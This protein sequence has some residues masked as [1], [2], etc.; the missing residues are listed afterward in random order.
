MLRIYSEEYVCACVVGGVPRLLHT[1]AAV[2]L[3]ALSVLCYRVFQASPVNQ[4][5]KETPVRQETWDRRDLT[6]VMA[7]LVRMV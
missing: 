4:A 3:D 6:D 1:Y 2:A 7:I 5:P